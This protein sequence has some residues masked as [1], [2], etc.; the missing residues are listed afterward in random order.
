M[1]FL[2]MICAYRGEGTEST[3]RCVRCKNS[4]QIA[5]RLAWLYLF[6]HFFR[7]LKNFVRL[8]NEEDLSNH[9]K[10]QPNIL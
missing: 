2:I 3:R 5:I 7:H 8:W 6:F 10:L 4:F 1:V 9:Q